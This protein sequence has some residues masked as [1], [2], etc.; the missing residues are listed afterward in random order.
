MLNI[1]RGII[2]LGVDIMETREQAPWVNYL[3]I[4]KNGKRKLRFFTPF[5]IRKAYKKHL[6]YI[7]EC[8]KNGIPISK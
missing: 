8:S 6:D 5:K 1:I 3:V 7:K 2:I 4:K